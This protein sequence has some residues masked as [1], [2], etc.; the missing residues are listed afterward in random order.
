VIA[1]L[2]S[3]VSLVAAPAIAESAA[4]DSSI[5]QGAAAVVPE[6]T[7][8]MDSFFDDAF[9]EELAKSSNMQSADPFENA[10]RKVFAFNQGVDRFL[11]D[12]ITRGYRFM[13][14]E[15]ARKGVRRL[16]LNLDSPRIFVNDLLQLRFKDAGVT[17]TRLVLNT[18]LG[19]GGFLEAGDAAGLPRHDADFGQTLARYGVVSGPY[20]VI[21][22]FG[23]STVRD[24]VGSIID[25]AFQPLTYILGPGQLLV[26]VYVNGGS[27][28]TTLDATY[29]KV[30]ALE[31]SSVDFYAAMRSAYLQNRRAAIAEVRPAPEP[32]PEPG[33]SPTGDVQEGRAPETHADIS[34]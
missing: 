30:R 20:V 8:E 1:T 24:G 3:A 15:P 18:T 10:N 12:P 32:V 31:M 27:G 22:V 2:A 26:N 9:E 23:P 17:L 14:P 21:P 11:F 19:V 33:F 7:D 13:V 4:I 29:D 34:Y 16:F 25:L 28:L 6:I 5:P